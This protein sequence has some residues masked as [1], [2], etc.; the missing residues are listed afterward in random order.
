MSFSIF[1]PPRPE[2]KPIPL[3]QVIGPLKAL[4]RAYRMKSN[5]TSDDDDDGD[6]D[7]A[8]RTK[9]A[10]TTTTISSNTTKANRTFATV[11]TGGR[12]VTALAPDPKPAPA[13][14][15]TKGA[16]TDAPVRSDPPAASSKPI[17]KRRARRKQAQLRKVESSAES[18]WK[19][20][21]P[22]D[23]PPQK[24][25]V[26]SSASS[27]TTPSPR[28]S[29]APSPSTAYKPP[30]WVTAPPPAP[31][32]LGKMPPTPPYEPPKW[33]AETGKPP[34]TPKKK[35]ST[36]PF[37]TTV[38]DEILQ[39]IKEFSRQDQ[40]IPNPGP[41]YPEGY[42][43]PPRTDMPRADVSPPVKESP[44]PPP[45]PKEKEPAPPVEGSFSP[46]RNAQAGVNVSPSSYMKDGNRAFPEY[47]ANENDDNN[48][49]ERF[50]EPQSSLAPDARPGEFRETAYRHTAKKR[51]VRAYSELFNPLDEPPFIPM[52]QPQQRY[53]GPQESYSNGPQQG[54]N[55]P[56]G[57]GPQQRYNGPQQQGYNQPQGY[58]PQQGYNGPPQRGFNQPQG[59]GPQQGYGPNEDQFYDPY[60]QPYDNFK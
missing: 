57:Y 20:V 5:F 8:V 49:P 43:R 50:G 47:E 40:K 9:S 51:F 24:K 58:G 41:K 10:P 16:T 25:T 2:R 1:R 35:S 38:S 48:L 56:L 26:S 7:D 3:E 12:K 44:P 23:P 30:E 45:A 29:R 14:V 28:A 39:L 19:S 53:S 18:V 60:A 27:K 31:A 54:Y 33:L 42:K 32:T 46:D 37:Q 59:F 21:L 55:Q 52:Q 22:V 15:K 17:S 13:P 11:Q 6:D 34:P 4:S 36:K